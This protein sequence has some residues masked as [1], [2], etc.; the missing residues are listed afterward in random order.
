MTYF[1]FGL[2]L[3]QRRDPTAIAV[4]ERTDPVLNRFDPQVYFSLR[5]ADTEPRFA[6]RHL[7]RIPL[8]TTYPDVV[9]RVRDLTRRPEVAGRLTLVVDGTGV[10]R[11][12][13]DLLRQAD[14]DC[15]LVEVSI[16]AG[17][18]AHLTKGCW[19]LPKADLTGALQVM[20]ERGRV[21]FGPDVPETARLIDELMALRMRPGGGWM[22]GRPDDLA[23]A[24][25]LACWR[26]G[27]D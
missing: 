20:V 7:E 14:L 18:K 23:V 22:D 21:S 3:G 19:Y 24:L 16:T 15:E 25:C 27:R 11:A 9:A 2:D 26:A 1:Y 10:G 4:V 12:V 13:V 8:G 5:Q 17:A 6:V